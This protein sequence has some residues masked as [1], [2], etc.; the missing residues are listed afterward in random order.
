MHTGL[1]ILKIFH[2]HV[3]KPKC[4]TFPKYLIKL[5]ETLAGMCELSEQMV[6]NPDVGR[7]NSAF[8]VNQI[9]SN[10]KHGD[11]RL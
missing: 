5:G 4:T 3:S 10:S 9:F 7:G 6:P 1:L 11:W 2:P 8:Q